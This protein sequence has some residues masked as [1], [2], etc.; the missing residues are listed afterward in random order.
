MVNF[1][2][3][4][5]AIVTVPE[6]EIEPPVPADDVM[7]TVLAV[8]PCWLTVKS[9]PPIDTAADRDE[10]AVLAATEY[11]TVPGPVPPAP[12]VIVIQEA[13]F[14]ALQE[15]PAWVVTVTLPDPPEEPK[16]WLAGV[17]E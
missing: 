5:G 3:D 17:I 14:D 2:L 6:G 9:L 7:V 13:L 12:A 8:A 11:P 10:G 16:D 15:H 1:L 4:P